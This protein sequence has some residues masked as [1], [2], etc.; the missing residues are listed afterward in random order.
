MCPRRSIRFSRPTDRSEVYKFGAGISLFQNAPNQFESI[1]D[2]AVSDR[3]LQFFD[4]I[5]PTLWRD[6][7]GLPIYSSCLGENEDALP[8][9][10][11]P[12]R[13]ETGFT[14]Q[15]SVVS[16]FATTVPLLQNDHDSTDYADYPGTIFRTYGASTDYSNHFK[17]DAKSVGFNS[18]PLAAG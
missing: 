9:G 5:S 6:Q 1:V 13:L 15:D 7:M 10:W 11:A 16:V 3:F 12:L 2:L 8:E 14:L 17:D 18:P 4:Q